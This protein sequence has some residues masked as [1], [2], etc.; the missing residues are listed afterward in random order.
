MK[1]KADYTPTDREQDI[2]LHALGL[3]RGEKSYRNYYAASEGHK[4]YKELENLASHGLMVNRKDLFNDF[5]GLVY[6]VTESGKTA[7]G[8]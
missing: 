7:V 1:N 5:G 2:I 4:S 6:H 8:A 3:D